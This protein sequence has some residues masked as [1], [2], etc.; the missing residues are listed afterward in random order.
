MPQQSQVTPWC[1]VAPVVWSVL[2]GAEVPGLQ[3]QHH[4]WVTEEWVCVGGGWQGAAVLEDCIGGGYPC[5]VIA[6]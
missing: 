6:P 1:T 5:G 3:L 4:T 2:V